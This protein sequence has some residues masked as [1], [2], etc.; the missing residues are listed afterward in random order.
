MEYGVII[1]WIVVVVLVVAIAWKK[2]CKWY[3]SSCV[4]RYTEFDTDECVENVHGKCPDKLE[5]QEER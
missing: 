1:F 4:E 3:E 2:R 5:P